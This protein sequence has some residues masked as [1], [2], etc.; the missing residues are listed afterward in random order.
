M[1]IPYLKRGFQAEGYCVVN[2]VAAK[3]VGGSPFDDQGPGL[4]QFD[5]LDWFSPGS[6]GY[7]GLLSAASSGSA[8]GAR[9][10]SGGTTGSGTT[11]VTSGSSQ[12]KID[13]VWDSSVSSAPAGFTTAVTAAVQYLESLISN[14]VT[15]NIDV[16]YG[17]IA[18]SALGGDALGESEYYLTSVSYSQLVAALKADA[19]SATD[20]SMLASL[21]AS[22]PVS[23]TY[24]ITTAQAKA[25]GL[26]SAT[27]SATDGFVGFSSTLPFTYNDAAGVAAGTYDLNGVVLHELTETMGRMLLTGSTIGSTPNSY[28]LLDLAHYSAA[29]TRDFAASVA[30]YLSVDG[31]ATNLANFNT[32]SG[33]DA[34][35]WAA[36][37]GND[38]FDAFSNSG[39]INGISSADQAALDAIGW[40]LA[41]AP[42]PPA[43]PPPAPPPPSVGTPTGV[44]MAAMAGSVG[45]ST[46][47][48]GLNGNM[49][50]ATVT[51]TG[52]PSGDSYSYALSGAGA[53]SFTLSRSANGATLATSSAGAAGSA[54]GKLYA[55]AATATDTSSGNSSPSIPANVMVGDNNSDTIILTS[56]PGLATS[57]VTFIYGLGGNDVINASGMTGKVYIDGGGGSD[58]MTGEAVPTPICMAP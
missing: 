2:T 52:G 42:P 58:R 24:W 38:S 9:K 12:F 19:T 32:V 33:G 36:S 3:H 8:G 55:L 54:S 7:L 57:A 41:G 1:P 16:G 14:P 51:Q 10:T 25:L 48:S 4:G 5:S 28:S 45:V 46:G 23:G 29:G 37:A 40:N 26:A 30:G 20:A 15:I 47:A 11:V 31:G 53:A 39:V 34:G 6:G 35:D 49:S 18:G 50:L 43:P 21:P 27:G 22:S 13:I 56:L 17:E 44:I